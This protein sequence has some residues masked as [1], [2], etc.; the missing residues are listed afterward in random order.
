MQTLM[1]YQHEQSIKYER[2][3][4]KYI[5]NQAIASP[6]RLDLFVFSSFYE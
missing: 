6:V 2:I 5:F 1:Q 4:V 3:A